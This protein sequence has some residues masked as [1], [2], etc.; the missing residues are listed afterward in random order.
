MSDYKKH[1]LVKEGSGIF[2]GMYREKSYYNWNN[3]VLLVVK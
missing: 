3:V 2:T 1:I